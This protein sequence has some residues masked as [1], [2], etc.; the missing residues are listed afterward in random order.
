MGLEGISESAVYNHRMAGK[1]LLICGILSSLLWI[2]ADIFAIF[3]YE[4]YS[5]TSQ[6]VSELS[7]IGSPTKSL[8]AVTGL[9]YEVLLFLFGIGVLFIAG[10]NRLCHNYSLKKFHPLMLI[11]Y[12]NIGIR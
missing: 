2:G 12:S 7:A 6:T 3:Q 10:Q 5:F 9:I 1:T 11:F 8:L 4:G